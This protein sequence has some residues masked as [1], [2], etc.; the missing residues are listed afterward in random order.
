M[1]SPITAKSEPLDRTIDRLLQQ[2]VQLARFEQVTDPGL[3]GRNLV[4]P[5]LEARAKF[6]VIR[7]GGVQKATALALGQLRGRNEGFV[8]G[9]ITKSLG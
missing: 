7:G 5:D 3:A 9:T 8:L 6:I 2:D 1:A 4:K